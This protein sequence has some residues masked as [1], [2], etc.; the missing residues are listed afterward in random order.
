VSLAA[1]GG[2]LFA[3]LHAFAESKAADHRK[4]DIQCGEGMQAAL[5]RL[6]G[7][8]DF[9]DGFNGEPSEDG[10]NFKVEFKRENR[11]DT[12][13]LKIVSTG[14]SGSVKQV[15]ERTLR[16]RLNITEENDSVWVNEDNKAGGA[17]D[18]SF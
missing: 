15:T 14:T 11:G 18:E 7:S 17:L 5:M 3:L 10:A 4:A 13:L 1:L 8:P 16:Y 2:A 6:G 12:L 9:S